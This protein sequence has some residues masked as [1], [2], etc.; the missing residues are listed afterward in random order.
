MN[1]G[2]INHLF[3]IKNIYPEIANQITVCDFFLI[4]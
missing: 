1:L 3:I 4:L 2:Q